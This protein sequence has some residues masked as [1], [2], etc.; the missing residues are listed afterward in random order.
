MPI[1]A[2]SLPFSSTRTKFVIVI[3][4]KSKAN[5]LKRRIMDRLM[6]K[7][8]ILRKKKKS[9]RLDKV[10]GVFYRS[11]LVT[12]HHEVLRLSFEVGTEMEREIFLLCHR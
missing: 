7:T 5:K 4:F 2:I 6:A 8:N 10:T 11:G 1:Y 9:Q 3:I 12:L